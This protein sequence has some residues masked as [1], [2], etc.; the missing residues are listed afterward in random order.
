MSPWKLNIHQCGLQ[1]WLI[2]DFFMLEPITGT[3][4]DIL[5]K[6]GTGISELDFCLQKQTRL[7]LNSLQ[8]L[9]ICRNIF[10]QKTN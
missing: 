1:I 7:T 8:C 10:G 6:Y 4:S 5:V 9:Y 2:P 3:V